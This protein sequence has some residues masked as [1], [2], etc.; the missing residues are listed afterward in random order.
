MFLD[1]AL[2]IAFPAIDPIAFSIGP[3][4][5]R[6]YGLSY[7]VSILLAWAYA[8]K[9]VST[10]RI[11]PSA[12]PPMTLVDIDDFVLWAAL[13][14]VLGGRLG[15]IFFYD[16]PAVM[17]NPLRAIEIWNGGMSFHG[18]ITGVTI[19][20][21]AFARMRGIPMLSLFDVIGTVAVTGLFLVRI[22]NFINQELW[23]KVTDLPWAVIFPNGGPFSRHPSQIYEALGEGLINGIILA[24]LVFRKDSLKRPGLTTGVFIGVYGLV[25]MAVELVREPD[26]QLGYLLGTN[27]LTMGMILSTPMVALGLWLITRARP[28]STSVEG[29]R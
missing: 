24:L 29:P 19:A 15:Y 3:V 7:V 25:R 5:V 12:T 8:R 2:A 14:I 22:A 10:P 17:A 13:G 6:W 1:P 9:I 26:P 20:M 23:G 28:A 16:F 21:I 4:D 18:G 11:W 27:W